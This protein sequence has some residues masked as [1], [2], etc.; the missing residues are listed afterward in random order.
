[1]RWF[2]DTLVDADPMVN[3]ASWQWVA[4]SGA[5][6][7]PYFRIFNPAS[8]GEKF[9]PDGK[10]VR[11]WVEEMRDVPTRHI[12]APWEASEGALVRA[13]VTLGKPYPK[14]VVDLKPGRDRALAAYQ[15]MKEAAA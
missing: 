8:Q 2:E 14:P 5:D 10:Y 6:A 13:G 7:A 9:D 11:Q 3:A 4:G 12:H 15:E 1:M